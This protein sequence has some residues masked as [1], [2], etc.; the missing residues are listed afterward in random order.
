MQ[1]SNV[2]PHCLGRFRE[3]ADEIGALLMV[4]MARFAGLVAAGLHPS[5]VPF[6]D[7]VTTTIH[8]TLG[9]PRSGMIL[10]REGFQ[11]K[12]ESRR[13]C[14]CRAAGAAA[15]ATS[16]SRCCASSPIAC[17]S[18]SRWRPSTRRFAS[19][20]GRWLYENTQSRIHVIVTHG[21]LRSLAKLD[22]AES[23]VGKTRPRSLPR[24]R[25]RRTRTRR[26]PS[27]SARRPSPAACCGRAWRGRGAPCQSASA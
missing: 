22:L 6:A 26:S 10:C 8:K 20:L 18:R 3:I 1:L 16:R 7:V 11:K 17:R 19:R 12:I 2:P 23:R 14:S 5:P 4:D 9:G 27:R 25:R 15:T 21:F 24:R 13:A